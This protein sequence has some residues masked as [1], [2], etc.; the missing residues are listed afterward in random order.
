MINDNNNNNKNNNNICIVPYRPSRNFRGQMLKAEA[1]PGG[2]AQ[3]RDQ[4]GLKTLPSVNH[5]ITDANFL[6][7]WGI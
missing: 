1:K 5:I 3:A 6:P 7:L 4:Y 2:R